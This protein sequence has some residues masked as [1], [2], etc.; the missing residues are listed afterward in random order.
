MIR[1]FTFWKKENFEE[2]FP[3]IIEKLNDVIQILKNNNVIMVIES[4]PG[5]NVNNSQ[6]L[7]RLM[8]EINSDWIQALW[9]PGNNLFVDGAEKP[10][11]NAYR[12]IKNYIAHIHVKDAIK[13]ND[14]G[15]VEACC[16]GTGQV[17]FGTIFKKLLDDNYTGWLSLET[18]YRLNK[19]IPKSLLSSPQGYSFS[20]GGEEASIECLRSWNEMMKKI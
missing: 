10:Y 6:K 12:R 9:D 14:N 18:H 13:N 8:K 1:G 11:P 2:I 4:D 7:G 16:I 3:R 5:T 20:N 17:G 15:K 19:E